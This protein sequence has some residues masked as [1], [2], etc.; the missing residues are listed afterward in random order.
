MTLLRVARAAGG[1]SAQCRG[2]GAG[3]AGRA[4]AGGGCRGARAAAGPCLPHARQSHTA[5]RRRRECCQLWYSS[6]DTPQSAWPRQLQGC[7]SRC[8]R[9]RACKRCLSQVSSTPVGATSLLAPSTAAQLQHVAARLQAR[10]DLMCDGPQ[11]RCGARA[12]AGAGRAAGI[13]HAR[14]ACGAARP[15]CTQRLTGA[16]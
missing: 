8:I 6:S 13:D 3:D 11:R 15:R 16:C 10:Q 4:D 7:W 9:H 14:R 5:D 1:S 2:G 12:R